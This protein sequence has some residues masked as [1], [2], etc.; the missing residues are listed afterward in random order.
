MPLF[1]N[2]V[3]P[4]GDDTEPQM[5]VDFI[6]GN[7]S[8]P[9]ETATVKETNTIFYKSGQYFTLPLSLKQDQLTYLFWKDGKTDS[10]TISYQRKFDFQSEKCGFRVNYSDLKVVNPTTFK[11][12]E[13]D[14]YYFGGYYEQSFH[15]RVND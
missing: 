12:V 1:S 8:N 13:V 15:I 2:C 10:L 6:N 3:E 9:Y 4:C 11:N 14:P 5:M 7:S